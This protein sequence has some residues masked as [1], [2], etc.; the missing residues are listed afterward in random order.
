MS[1]VDKNQKVETE[2]RGG[3]GSK[4]PKGS[5]KKRGVWNYVLKRDR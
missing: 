2:M 5:S 3:G 4:R 1:Q